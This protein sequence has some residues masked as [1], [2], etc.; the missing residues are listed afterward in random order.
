MHRVPAERARRPERLAEG[1][2][3]RPP[4]LFKQLQGRAARPARPRCT[5]DGI[6]ATESSTSASRSRDDTS[7]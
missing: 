3:H 2:D 7:I 5:A 6:Y 1:V 4:E